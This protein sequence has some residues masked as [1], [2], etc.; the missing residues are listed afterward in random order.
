MLLS[1]LLHN[2]VLPTLQLTEHKAKADS[3][4][5]NCE[6]FGMAPPRFESIAGTA[7]DIEGT[8]SSWSLLREYTAAL[9]LL[10]DQ[11]WIRCVT[12]KYRYINCL[13]VTFKTL[14]EASFMCASVSS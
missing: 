5:A 13:H 9:K 7:V 10:A 1:T 12:E 3:L 2:A 11:D 4:S 14:Q 8:V 6:S